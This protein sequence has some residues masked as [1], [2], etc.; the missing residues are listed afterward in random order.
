MGRKSD[1]IL[2]G[3]LVGMFLVV[4]SWPYLYYQLHTVTGAITGNS[5]KEAIGTFYEASSVGQRIFILSQIILLIAIIAAVFIVAN[6]VNSKSNLRKKDYIINGENKRSRT[7]LDV[8]Y[9]MLEKR[10]EV[11][12]EGVEQAFHISPEIAL[13]WFKV[14]ENGELAEIDYPRFGKPVLSL[15]K[16]DKIIEK[17]AE[18]E[19]SNRDKKSKTTPKKANVKK[20]IPKKNKVKKVK[21]FKKIKKKAI[22][23]NTKAKRTPNKK[24]AKT[25]R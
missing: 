21:Q 16:K 13:E 20:S 2:L 8:L 14:L 10:G 1:V 22:K 4:A 11:N 18:N 24:V 5:V 9:E 23:K 25:K 12:M 6:K 3:I 17:T 7:D 15:P 19:N